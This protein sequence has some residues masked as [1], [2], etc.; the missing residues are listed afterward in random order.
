MID[1]IGPQIKTRRD[2]FKEKCIAIHPY[3]ARKYPALL[4]L[5]KHTKHPGKTKSRGKFKWLLY[6]PEFAG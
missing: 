1:T 3:R 4:R 2:I 6:I 5:S